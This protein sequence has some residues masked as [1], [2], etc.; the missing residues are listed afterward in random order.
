MTTDDPLTSEEQALIDRAWETHAA[1]RP[2]PATAEARATAYH[3][4][5][6]MRRFGSVRP[7]L[8][9]AEIKTI[10]NANPQSPVY[11]DM[12]RR[13]VE[14]EPVGDGELVDI[15]DRHFYTLL[16]ATTHH[17]RL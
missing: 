17:G 16:P 11:R 7:Q 14:D 10:A 4:W 2:T 3:F 1:A 12:F 6:N 15:N 8:T 13:T 9:G 5:M